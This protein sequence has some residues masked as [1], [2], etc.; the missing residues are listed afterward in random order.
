M[1]RYHAA[2]DGN[3]QQL[4]EFKEDRVEPGTI[5]AV[6][7]NCY[8]STDYT[9]LKA[10][11][12]KV[13]RNMLKKF[14]E[15]HGKK[16]V[17]LLIPAH[18]KTIIGDMAERPGAANGMLKALRVLLRHAVDMGL[19]TDNPARNVRKFAVNSEGFHS[20]TE[21]DVAAFQARHDLGSRAQHAL[22]LLLYTGQRRSDVVRMGWQHIDGEL[23]IAVQDKAGV[24]LRV[25]IHPK[26]A[27]A[28]GNMPRNNMTFLLTEAGAPF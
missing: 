3:A 17:A 13:R 24:M 18:V 22:S 10:S 23:L 11:T 5:D 8:C 21:E 25:P 16:R 4:Q 15:Q 14:R 12:Q 9:K 1:Q 26:P 20:W 2:L 7:V 19:L 6:I 27:V 28:I